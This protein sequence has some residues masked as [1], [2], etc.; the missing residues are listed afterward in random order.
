MAF[1]WYGMCG[2]KI[3]IENPVPSSVYELPVKTQAIQPY[4]Y[5]HPY[6]KKT[7]LWLFGLPKLKPTNI[8]TPK[9]GYVCGNSE[10]WKKQAALGE[11][12]GKEK[13]AKHR[14]KTFIGW[15]N[16]MADQWAGNNKG[17]MK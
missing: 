15:A 12:I 4:E 7:Y 16:A 13:S 8:V 17:E 11:V 6:T 5:G 14:S 2:N 9:G 3:A 10:I 1:Y